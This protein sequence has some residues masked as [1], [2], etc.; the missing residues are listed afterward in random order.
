MMTPAT[1]KSAKAAIL[2]LA[3]IK[4][5][6]ERFDDGDIGVFHAIES[7]VAAVERHRA[8]TARRSIREG[9]RRRAA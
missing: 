1:V 4:A 9:R 2:K 5:S 8:T 7:I 3:E 6:I